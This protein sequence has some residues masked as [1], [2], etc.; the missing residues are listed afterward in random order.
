[1]KLISRL[2]S[3]LPFEGAWAGAGRRGNCIACRPGSPGCCKRGWFT[4]GVA[5]RLSGRGLRR[6]NP[7][8]RARQQNDQAPRRADAAPERRRPR[9]QPRLCGVMFSGWCGLPVGA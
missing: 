7:A 9:T 3:F 2:G 6:V 8:V 4:G 5:I 1:M